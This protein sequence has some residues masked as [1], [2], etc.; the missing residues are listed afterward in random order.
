MQSGGRL[1][2]PRTRAAK[3]RVRQRLQGQQHRRRLIARL[4]RLLRK[5]RKRARLLHSG[6]VALFVGGLGSFLGQVALFVGRR[7]SCLG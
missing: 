6:P 2:R 1:G 4:A 3:A 7:C 5:G